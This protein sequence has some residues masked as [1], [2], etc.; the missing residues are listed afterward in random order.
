MHSQN[1]QE[2]KLGNNVRIYGDVIQ[3]NGAV[4]RHMELHIHM[5]RPGE[6]PSLQLTNL[7]SVEENPNFLPP[8][9][10]DPLVQSIVNGGERLQLCGLGGMGKST[11][12]Q[13]LNRLFTKKGERVFTHIAYFEYQNNC[14]EMLMTP[15]DTKPQDADTVQFLIRQAESGRL[16]ILIDDRSQTTQA[17]DLSPLKPIHATIVLASRKPCPGYTTVDV[18]EPSNLLSADDCR[19]LYLRERYSMQTRPELSEEETQRLDDILDYRAARHYLVVQRLGAIARD[20][21]MSVSRLEQELDEKGFNLH[22]ADAQQ[23]DEEIH[24]LYRIEDV[25]ETK[26]RLL[27]AISAFPALALPQAQWGEWLCKYV[28]LEPMECIIQLTALKNGTWLIAE[29]D[30]L[31]MHLIVA[32]SVAGQKPPA[33]GLVLAMV[34]EVYYK[35]QQLRRDDRYHWHT[36]AL[37]LFYTA[38]ELLRIN[39]D[40]LC[41]LQKQLINHMYNYW[42]YYSVESLQLLREISK[43]HQDIDANTL[44]GMG[45]LEITLGQIEAAQEHYA[46]AEQLYRQEQNNLGLANTL[47]SMGDLESRLGQIEAAQKHYAQAEQLYRQEQVNLGLANTL[48]SMGDL[49]NRL[50]QIEAAQQ[51]F[52]QAEQ[53]FRQEQ[54]NLGLA[55]TLH[56]IGVMERKLEQ[57]EAAQQHFAQAEQLYLQ[58][59]DNLGLAN[60][61]FSMG[62]LERRLGQIEAA[63]RHFAQAEQFYRQEQDNLGLANTL[64]RMGVMESSLEQIE[65]AQ[66]HFAQAEHLYRQEQFSLGLANTLRSMGDLEKSIN[67]YIAACMLYETAV[68][69]YQQERD[70]MGEAY[71]L[72]ELCRTY[73]HTRERDFAVSFFA[74]VV[75][76]FDTFPEYT[77]DYVAECLKEAAALLGLAKNGRGVKRLF[78]KLRSRFSQFLRRM[79]L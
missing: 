64:H 59:Q 16:L 6:T 63:Q 37:S 22:D 62:D 43:N 21:V 50:E 56:R 18:A 23:L 8:P 77:K 61:L 13:Q 68:K 66:R 69:L 51:H 17:I 31:K 30:L 33:L 72:A 15:M 48:K 28:E 5:E 42:Q 78:T 36:L 19:E 20:G 26:Q 25:D 34:G 44:H 46:Q 40:T 73:P 27:S 39:D 58:E 9:Y 60:T 41:R 67:N 53:L 65:A 38:T 70:P 74:D 79:G 75:K 76:K 45:D 4:D 32:Q 55:N 14:A 1:R 11:V 12:L 47:L 54:D 52:A 24:K 57:I 29:G 10:F 2:Q 3:A 49:E 7:G 71:T 35:A